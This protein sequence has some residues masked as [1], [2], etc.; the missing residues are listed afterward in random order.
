MARAAGDTVTSSSASPA[1]ASPSTRPVGSETVNRPNPAA[2]TTVIPFSTPLT[3]AIL[4]C[5]HPSPRKSSAGTSSVVAPFDRYRRT[6][7]GKSRSL[8][9]ATPS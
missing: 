4:L 3:S 8:Q 5:S 9:I 1:V 7:P 2:R 6:S